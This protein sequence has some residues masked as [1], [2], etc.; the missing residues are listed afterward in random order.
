MGLNSLPSVEDVRRMDSETDVSKSNGFVDF[1][2]SFEGTEG[3]LIGNVS[4]E[5]VALVKSLSQARVPKREVSDD[6]KLFN[7]LLKNKD[8]VVEKKSLEKEKE[9]VVTDEK[10]KWLIIRRLS[11]SGKVP[12]AETEDLSLDASES[13]LKC[14]DA[15]V[16]NPK[17]QDDSLVFCKE[18][19]LFLKRTSFSGHNRFVHKKIRSFLC[20]T[21]GYAAHTG[22]IL[23][24][25][26]QAVHVGYIFECNSC[27]KKFNLMKRLK[28]HQEM[29]HFN[30]QNVSEKKKICHYCGLAFLRL[31]YLKTHLLT[32]TGEAP[33]QC[34]YCSRKFKFRWAL[35]QHER[36]HTGVKPY[37]C[38]FCQ[39]VFTQNKVRKNH[40]SRVHGY[41]RKTLLNE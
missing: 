13:T 27:P 16:K 7:K 37:K 2:F 10:E 34:Q 9:H 29:H 23:R 11:Q 40:E 14:L 3:P 4:Q 30:T 32:H 17:K 19:N 8:V 33:L 22:S 31:S 39:E 5:I 18:C 24:Q 20:Q 1:R 26:M 38:Q 6:V 25:H 15:M 41:D 36:L 12:S 35:K 21:C 28:K